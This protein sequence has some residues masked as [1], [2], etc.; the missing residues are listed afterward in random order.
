[1]VILNFFENPQVIFASEGAPPVSTTPVASLP[2]VLTTLAANFA[3]G[4][5]VVVDTSGK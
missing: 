1:M 4:T 3:T 5:A 2:P